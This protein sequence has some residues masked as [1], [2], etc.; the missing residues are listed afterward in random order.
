MFQM[1][2]LIFR[3]LTDCLSYLF[4]CSSFLLINPVVEIRSF[5]SPCAG[6]FEAWKVSSLGEP[7]NG[8]FVYVQIA[9]HVPHGHGSVGGL[10][11]VHNLSVFWTITG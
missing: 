8:L 4:S 6:N 7:I 1:K 5:E 9:S 3:L 2:L 11:H 10:G